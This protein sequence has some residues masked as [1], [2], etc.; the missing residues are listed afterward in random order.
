MKR[1]A[2][3]QPEVA[4]ETEHPAGDELRSYLQEGE[5]APLV[6]MNLL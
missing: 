1:S 3:P 6:I 5:G 4:P 2:E